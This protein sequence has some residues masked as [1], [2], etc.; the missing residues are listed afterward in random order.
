[1]EHCKPIPMPV[2][3]SSSLKLTDGSPP[4][5]GTLY[6]QTMGSLQYLLLSRHDIVFAV[7]KLSQFMHSPT[8]Q[9]WGTI[10]HLNWY[11]NGT[12]SYGIQLQQHS[13][14]SLRA[15]YDVDW[16]SDPGDRISTRAYVVFLGPIPIF[17][18]FQEVMFYCLF[19]YQ[20]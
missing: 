9:H 19:I 2:A 20:S 17:L 4:A 8:T 12:K 18:E 10:K 15:L 1:M 14:L 3:T 13:S 7:N 11:L 16:A 6:C 5:D